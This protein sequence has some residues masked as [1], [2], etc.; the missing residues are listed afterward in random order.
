MSGSTEF[1]FCETL[2]TTAWHIR[3]YMT[4]TLEK[5]KK[6]L[7]GRQAA[8]DIEHEFNGDIV[9]ID[10]AIEIFSQ[11]DPQREKI[12]LC[13]TCKK[14]YLEILSGKRNQA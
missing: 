11:L 4:P 1:V 12:H 10:K 6:A 7:C 2:A 14:L 8:W 13:A 3:V 9:Y 5:I